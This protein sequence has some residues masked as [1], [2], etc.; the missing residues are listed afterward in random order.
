PVQEFA[1]ERSDVD[2]RFVK[3][4][5]EGKPG[6]IWI[7]TRDAG[8]L[9][10]DPVAGTTNRYFHNPL[11]PRSLNSNTITS[12]YIDRSETLWIGTPGGLDKQSKFKYKF[13]DS[14][15]PLDSGGADMSNYVVAIYEDS[16]TNLW[17]GTLQGGIIQY[18]RNNREYI[19]PVLTRNE[20]LAGITAFSFLEDKRGDFYLGS[21][22]NGLLKAN[23]NAGT[24]ER[25]SIQ[26]HVSDIYE[27]RSGILWIATQLN[28]LGRFDRA[29]KSFDYWSFR[30]A[31]AKES[32]SFDTTVICEDRD[33]NLWIGTNGGGLH[34][35]SHDRNTFVQ[36]QRKP[37][38]INSISNNS[39]L[40]L[41][42]DDTG[43]LWVGT[44]GGLNRFDPQ[45]ETFRRF[46]QRDVLPDNVIC[47][48]LPDENGNL[49]LSTTKG[50]ARFDPRTERCDA[51]DG[52]D[53][54]KGYPFTAGAA[55]KSRSGGLLFGG[56][57][58]FWS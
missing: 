6:E 52:N 13:H 7:G 24:L 36:Y 18:D 1:E 57:N 47:G 34:K 10:F 48:I 9:K 39:I 33:G 23:R 43:I 14:Y 12:V 37:G 54:L 58:S 5:L 4:I 55:F 56:I 50:L 38:N 15:Y 49:W 2:A 11:S 51:Y 45:M 44:R 20:D 22:S 40:S 53:G 31:G 19:N 26:Q 27:D 16:D 21:T 25:L 8:L 35:F 41:Y 29:N 42:P 46:Y 28:G 17:L 3:C 32:A 30:Q